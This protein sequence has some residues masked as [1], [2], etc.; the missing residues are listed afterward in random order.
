M[1]SAVKKEICPQKCNM[2]MSGNQDDAKPV[3]TVICKR[4]WETGETP[5]TRDRR[6]VTGQKDGCQKMGD[7][8]QETG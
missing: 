7:K 3:P 4:R 5:K 1:K 2:K 8:R 6:H